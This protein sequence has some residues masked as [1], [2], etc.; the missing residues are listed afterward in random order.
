M[1]ERL[2]DAARRAPGFMPEDEGLALYRAGVAGAARGPLLEIGSYCGKSAIYLAAAARESG[3]VVYSIDHHR[4]SEEHQSGEEYHDPSLIDPA[5]GAVDSFPAFRRTIERA[6][7]D[8]VVV[9]IVSPSVVAA[10]GWGGALGL[11][12]IDGGHSER[13][14][15]DD[16]ECWAQFVVVGGLLV[17]HDVFPNPND[18]GRAPYEVYLR[19]TSSGA[20]QEV[21]STGSLCVLQRIRN[22]I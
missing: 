15:N 22:G 10:R 16:Y 12:F 4:G 21:G 7:L 13:A 6:G 8:D 5:S 11:V 18:G 9:A 1:D 19:A 3:A 17:I 2:R 14:V 20:F